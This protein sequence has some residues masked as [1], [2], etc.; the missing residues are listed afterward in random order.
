MPSRCLTAGTVLVLASVGILSAKGVTTRIVITGSELS[1]PIEL[2]DREVVAPFNVWSGP[3]TSLNGVEGT[4]GFIVDWRSGAVEPAI[5][6]LQQF[7]ISFFADE[8]PSTPGSAVYVVSYGIDR[9][10]GE[11]YVYLPGSSDPRWR[12]NV[13]SIIRGSQY[14]GHWFRATPTWQNVMRTYV[15]PNAARRQR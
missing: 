13:R 3:G 8:H 6:R 15:I 1:E 12:S 11:A 7:E 4:D 14:E 5:S 10:S 2:R 9:L